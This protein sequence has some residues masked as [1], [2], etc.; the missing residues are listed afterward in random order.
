MFSFTWTQ[1]CQR[2][3]QSSCIFARFY[4]FIDKFLR[5]L[6]Q[7]LPKTISHRSYQKIK[8]MSLFARFIS[9]P[10]VLEVSFLTIHSI[11]ISCIGSHVSDKYALTFDI[12]FALL[13]FPFI[14][15]I[16]FMKEPKTHRTRSLLYNSSYPNNGR[17][18]QPARPFGRTVCTLRG[19][20]VVKFYVVVAQNVLDHRTLV[21]CLPPTL[22][23][24]IS[25]KEEL[26]IKIQE[27]TKI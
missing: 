3:V 26:C 4:R 21:P 5:R 25:F 2:V 24:I 22:K 23:E 16:F 18:N 15:T 6:I 17:V 19:P 1:I 10:S 13:T 11:I 12:G 20:L 14:D 7:L 9:I 8:L 27:N